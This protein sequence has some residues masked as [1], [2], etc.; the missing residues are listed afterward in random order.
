MTDN[1][2]Q[3]M[4]P[5][6]WVPQPPPPA[7]QPGI[8][9]LRPVGVGEMISG[10]FRAMFRNW[11]PAI[12]LPLALTLVATGVTLPLLIATF[13]SFPQIHRNSVVSPEQLG[14]FA[15]LLVATVAAQLVLTTAA[16]VFSYGVNTIVT[17]RAVLGR[18]TTIG[19]ALR[20]LRPRLLPLYGLMA[21]VWLIMVAWIVVPPLLMVLFAFAVNSP[22]VAFLAFLVF[23][24]C[25]A[26]AVYLGISYSLATAALVL[27]PQPVLTAMRRSRWL[28]RD[29]W[30][31]V[32]GVLALCMVMLYVAS[33]FLQMPLSF[34]QFAQLPHLT[35]MGPN[36]DP[37]EL[38]NSMF[39]PTLLVGLVV[40]SA[41]VS[42]LGQPLIA[43]VNT[44]LYH[45]LRIR[46]ES[47]HLPLLA[48][49]QL[50]DDLSPPSTPPANPEATP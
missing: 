5:H 34:L 1:P 35:T 3:Y 26:V 23:C 10:S 50:P 47:F 40:V 29:N 4:Q 44:L 15:V 38:L 37:S 45:D 33:S 32:F 8:L 14:T 16:T 42:A 27:E 21:L 11:R 36:P 13:Q 24:A 2:E 46:K 22:A 6:E 19:Q 28:V 7:P 49:S 20:A 41:V 43:G 18:T 9:P 17:S 12:L 39:S 48:M 30:W 31:R 25:S